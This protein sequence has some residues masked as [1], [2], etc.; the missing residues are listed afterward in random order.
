M[1]RELSA[2]LLKNGSRL[3]NPLVGFLKLLGAQAL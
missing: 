1:F 3:L 2:Q